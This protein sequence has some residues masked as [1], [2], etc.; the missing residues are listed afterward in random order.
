MCVCEVCARALAYN[1]T[2][3]WYKDVEKI[4]YAT[5][6]GAASFGAK[7][8][9]TCIHNTTLYTYTTVNGPI[10][11]A[12]CI[13]RIFYMRLPYKSDNRESVDNI[14]TYIEKNRKT[15]F[16]GTGKGWTRSRFFNNRNEETQTGGK[17]NDRF[18]VSF[19]FL[20]PRAWR[21]VCIIDLPKFLWRSLVSRPDVKFMVLGVKRFYNVVVYLYTTIYTSI[22]VLWI[23]CLDTRLYILLN[24]IYIRI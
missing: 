3:Q 7:K 24:N 19:C 6:I 21:R 12:L 14:Y 2:A 10:Y 13:M 11:S 15:S 4:I 8:Y 9:I 17:R 20:P 22:A 23:V 5:V 16:P 18:F 1:G